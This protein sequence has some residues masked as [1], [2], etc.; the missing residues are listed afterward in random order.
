MATQG[1][2]E[3]RTTV[4][5][6]AGGGIAPA[7]SLVSRLMGEASDHRVWLFYGHHAGDHPEAVEQMLALKDRHLHRL[8]LGIVMEREP[9]EAELLSGKLDGA[10]IKAIASR[11]FDSGQVHNYFV[12]GP[13]SL[14]VV[15]ALVQRTRKG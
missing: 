13:Q 10:K 12:C 8:S 11:L 6:A 4:A 2:S 9:D 15:D 7:L 3:T 5:F 1:T 14:A